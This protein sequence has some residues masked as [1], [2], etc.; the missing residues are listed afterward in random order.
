MAVRG[1]YLAWRVRGALLPT[2][3][4]F[5]PSLLNDILPA[6]SNL[7]KRAD[8][9]AHEEFA[10]R[11]A[12]PAGEDCDGDMGDA[13]EAA[14]AKGQTFYDT[15]VGMRQATLNL[16]SAGLFHLT[17]Q[18]LTDLCHDASF[19]MKPPDTKL[20]KVAA[21]YQRH[22]RVDLGQLRNWS[23]VDE[24]RYLANAVKHGEGSSAKQLRKQRPELFEHPL[25]KK[26]WPGAPA[27]EKPLRLPMAGDDLYVTDEQFADY[28]A[29]AVDFFEALADY[30]DEHGEDEYPH[31]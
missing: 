16:F 31:P 21:W 7:Q 29:A 17:E 5:G 24:L 3:E 25:M 30:F 9:V 11:G 13:A 2:V 23:K 12:E 28:A 15:M 10:R 18:K 26:L 22:L 14:E 6:F 20:E 27:F 4:A 19:R 8:E 1:H